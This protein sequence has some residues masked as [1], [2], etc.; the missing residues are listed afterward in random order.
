MP[1]RWFNGLRSI[2]APIAQEVAERAYVNMVL[3]EQYPTIPAGYDT[4][5]IGSEYT[6]TPYNACIK[7]RQLFYIARCSVLTNHAV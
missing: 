4:C 3:Q 5:S 1:L 6:L 2:D 7:V